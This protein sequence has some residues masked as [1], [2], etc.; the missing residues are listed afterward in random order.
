[1]E[2]WREK[3]FTFVDLE[4]LSGKLKS[5]NLVTNNPSANQIRELANL[6][7]A[8]VIITGTAIATKSGDPGAILN[9][10][11][12]TTK[13]NSCNAALSLRAFNSDSGEIISTASGQKT[14]THVSLA[15]CERNA[16]RM[17]TT[18]V[19][20]DLYGLVLE[21][22]RKRVTGQSRVR[23]TVRNIDGYK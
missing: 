16:L 2:S 11:T 13:M 21:A 6:T 9:D 8:D 7:D 5:A 22:W 1:I 23:M 3:D 14:T 4:A 10:R 18:V 20:D 12:G 15:T 17:A 19:N